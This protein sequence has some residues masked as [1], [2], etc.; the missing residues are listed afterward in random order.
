MEVPGVDTVCQNLHTFYKEF[1]HL[2]AL[3]LTLL[4]IL[5]S[6]GIAPKSPWEDNRLIIFL[7]RGKGRSNSSPPWMEETPIVLDLPSST[8]FFATPVRP[9]P[10]NLLP[11]RRHHLPLFVST[12][13]SLPSSVSPL[14]LSVVSLS[15]LASSVPSPVF[16][17]L[18]PLS[19]FL[20]SAPTV[21]TP[22]PSRVLPL[23]PVFFF[24]VPAHTFHHQNLTSKQS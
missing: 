4:P 10:V 6:P 23:P 20:L 2:L 11:D 19:L 3:F 22:L 8:N 7:L 24:Q 5:P 21:V 9:L 17:S 1:L 15:L 16:F 14:S 13:P 18:L 12:V